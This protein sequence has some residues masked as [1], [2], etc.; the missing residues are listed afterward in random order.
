MQPNGIVTLTSDFGTADGYVGAM[1]GVMTRIGPALRL[2]DIAHDV[3]A[4]DVSHGAGTLATASRWFPTGTVH[5]A[6]VDPGVGTDRA[7]VVV[8]AGG[9]AFVGPDN[10]LLVEAARVTARASRPEGPAGPV[11]AWRIAAHPHL[12]PNRSSTFH[13]RDVFAP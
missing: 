5:L 12:L 9:H 1:K 11:S 2:H 10:G 8:L 7:P 13:G 3:P 6:V 4:Q